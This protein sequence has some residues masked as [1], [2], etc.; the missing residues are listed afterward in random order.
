MLEQMSH[1]SPYRKD[2]WAYS[3]VLCHRK[4]EVAHTMAKSEN[5]KAK[6][7]NMMATWENTKATS[8]N[9][10]ATWQNTMTKSEYMEALLAHLRHNLFQ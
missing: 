1:L 10:K 7:E 2:T 5:K 9:T 3:L 4:G 8:E 6:S